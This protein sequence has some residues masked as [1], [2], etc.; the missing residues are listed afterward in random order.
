MN[1][2]PINWRSL[3][4]HPV[5]KYIVIFVAIFLAFLIGRLSV[6]DVDTGS[7]ATTADKAE[8][9]ET[10]TPTVYT[11]SMHPQ[12][13]QP[14]P[15]DC[16]ICG[17]DLIPLQRQTDE[18]DSERRYSMT[19][20]AVALAEIRTTAV[21]R[22]FP[23]AEIRLVGNL[24]YDQTRV[25]SLT[26][27]FP[28]R[29]DR[30]YVN[31]TGIPVKKGEH[32]AL[33]FSPELLVA[34]NEL[35]TAWQSE[36]GG[37]FYRAARQKLL[38]W[39][40]LPDQIDALQD[41]GKAS[42]R[43]E[44]RAPM[45]GT[46]VER[47]IKEG[48]YVQTGDPLVTIADL[49][50]LWLMLKAWESDLQWLRYGQSV[51]FT[52]ETYPGEQ[53]TGTIA[54]LE[55]MFDRTTRTVS[56]RVNVP[57]EDRRLKPGMFARGIVK[58]QL[59]NSHDILAPD[60]AGKWIS[61]MH[62]EIVKDAPGDC[63]IC[64][65]PLVPA[66]ELGYTDEAN[67]KMPVVVPASAVLRTGTRAVVYV[68]LPDREM[69]TFE[70]REITL[71]PRAGDVF[72]VA[73]GLSEGEEVVT[74][75]AFKIDSSLQIQ[76]RPSMMSMDQENG[77]HA[78][79]SLDGEETSPLR[80]VVDVDTAAK[81]LPDYFE[82]QQTLAGDDFEASQAV[83]RQMMQKTGHHGPIPDLI[84]DMLAASSIDG[85][86]RPYFETLSDAMIQAVRAAPE[87]FGGS[88]YLMHCPMVYEDRGA[89][90]LQPSDDLLNPFFGSE[91]LY[92]GEVLEQ[93]K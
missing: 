41:E 38:L 70:G 22:Q 25:R 9:A 77:A 83:L 23:N 4:Q 32:L 2:Q 44:L 69:P 35:L 54:F 59:T 80:L 51:S 6:P 26:A 40:L 93:I 15:G 91:M 86:R 21:R 90:W 78:D 53:F 58:A 27:R 74:R 55:P 75:G 11:C 61:P 81:L 71:G 42:E 56:V 73:D 10:A 67:G 79:S 37:P 48:D 30:L 62:P 92:C 45:G 50:Q 39:D 16:P 63:D 72:V 3:G 14:D 5:T 24:D 66:E 46:V 68:K 19:E 49:S 33:V 47:N 76:A 18:S 57:N 17:M 31:Y 29:I 43:F 87:R 89:D 34:Q 1:K 52:V 88:I 12:I 8:G 36:P 82:L 84:H 13:K 28:A 20:S 85:M 64:G 7:R 65:M 60:L